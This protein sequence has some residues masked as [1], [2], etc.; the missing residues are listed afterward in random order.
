MLFMEIFEDQKLVAACRPWSSS[1]E[2]NFSAALL[3][4]KFKVPPICWLSVSPVCVKYVDKHPNLRVT[5]PLLCEKLP[6]KPAHESATS[7]FHFAQ[8][9]AQPDI[10]CYPL[11]LTSLT[12]MHS[13]SCYKLGYY[14]IINRLY[15]LGMQSGLRRNFIGT[16]HFFGKML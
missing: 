10:C 11:H 4:S 13:R 12:M 15:A 3:C 5:K 8:W 6:L 9:V 7:A 1:T 14:A 2:V 16:H